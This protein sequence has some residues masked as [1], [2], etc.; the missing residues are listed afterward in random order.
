MRVLQGLMGLDE[1]RKGK[2]SSSQAR[3]SCHIMYIIM[4]KTHQAI[5][6]MNVPCHQDYHI[7]MSYASWHQGHHQ[8][9]HQVMSS[10][11][12]SNQLDHKSSSCTSSSQLDQSPQELHHIIKIQQSSSN[13]LDH[14]LSTGK[15]MT[16]SPGAAS[17]TG[18]IK[19]SISIIWAPPHHQGPHG[20]TSAHHV[21]KHQSSYIV[22]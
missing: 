1:F 9:Y 13:Q 20:T 11:S 3:A 12:S 17:S 5:S 22:L 4:A 6:T 19:A 10:A 21:Y 16:P 2:G 18:I 8:G 7:I 15:Y 14:G